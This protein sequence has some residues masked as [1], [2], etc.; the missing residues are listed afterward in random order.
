MLVEACETR[1]VVDA[2]T[3]EV[4]LRVPARAAY[5]RIVRVGAA[6][7]ALR[8]GLGFG[9]I[10]DLRLAI[11]EAMILLLDGVPDDVDVDI[12]VQFRLTGGHLELEASRDRGHPIGDAAVHR[13]EA[14]AEGLVADYAVDATTARVRLRT[15]DAGAA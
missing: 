3:S 6:A 7:L 1:T 15:A 2:D 11:D 10:D 8:Q 14:I 9:Q 5:A 13:F 12:E 4:L